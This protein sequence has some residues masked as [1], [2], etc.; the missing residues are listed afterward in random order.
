MILAWNTKRMQREVEEL[1]G[2]IR[3]QTLVL[4]PIHEMI[5]PPGYPFKPPTLLVHQKDH[6]NYLCKLY[7]KYDTFI[8]NYHIPLE[9]NC[10]Q[11]ITTQWTPCYTAKHVWNEYHLYIQ[12][13]KQVASLQVAVKGLPFDDL[14]FTTICSFF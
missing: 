6:C 4:S 7:S 11:T 14:V 5:F 12:Q 9:C 3:G 1:G 8:R 2:T 10:N 13:L